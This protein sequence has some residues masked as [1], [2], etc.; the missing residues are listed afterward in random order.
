M[1]KKT[2]RT[3]RVRNLLLIVSM[4]LVVA[5]ASVGVTVAWLTD[6]TDEIVNTFTAGNI[7]ISLD[8]HVYDLENNALT[9]ELVSGDNRGNANY[10]IV[11]G[12]DLP[13]DP[14]ITIGA[15]S[16]EC[17]LFVKVVPA[18]WP[19]TGVTWEIADGW[20]ALSGVDN[21]YYQKVDE[22]GEQPVTRQVIKDDIVYVDDEMTKEQLNAITTNPTLTVTAYACQTAELDDVADAWAKLNP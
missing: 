13:K 18:N 10:K 2:R 4:M 17:W 20:E 5:M 11:P 1:T 22:T 16:E 9:T 3:R 21:V 6:K 12:V 15:N 7:T 14:Y 8:E 19:T